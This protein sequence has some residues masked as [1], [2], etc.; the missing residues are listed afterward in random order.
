MDYIYK[1][2]YIYIIYS[3]LFKCKLY[4]INSVLFVFMKIFYITE[5]FYFVDL[6]C[7]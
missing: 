4:I 7:I 5:C 6:H 3:I 2:I 1:Y